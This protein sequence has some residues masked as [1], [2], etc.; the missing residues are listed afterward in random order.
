MAQG[1]TGLII[2]IAG[3]NDRLTLT[4]ALSTAANRIETIAFADGTTWTHADLI[5]RLTAGTADDDTY[6][7]TAGGDTLAGQGGDDILLGNGGD[8]LLSGGSGKDRLEGGAGSDQLTGG[9]GEDLLIGGVGADLYVFAVG[10]GVDHIDDRGDN[11]VDRLR[12]DGYAASA[13]R[14]SRT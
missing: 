10:D 8:D 12:I 3:T 9:T 2:K 1:T 4:G 7:G 11:S 14:F 5:A 13:A 6:V